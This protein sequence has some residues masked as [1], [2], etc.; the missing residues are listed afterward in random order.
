M[1]RWRSASLSV[2][3]RGSRHQFAMALALVSALPLLTLYYL[4]THRAH[5]SAGAQIGLVAM[6]AAVIAS[7]FLLLAKYPAAIQKLRVY[8]TK[9]V[10][11]EVPEKITLVQG[12]D[13]VAAIE[14]SMNLIVERMHERV[15]DM[16]DELHRIEWI[17]T[18]NV[19]AS[20][21]DQIRSERRS[22]VIRLADS[23]RAGSPFA[24]VNAE[25]L[26]DILGDSLDL[27]EHS[28][29]V[30]DAEG[31]C[32]LFVLASAWCRLLCGRD[33]VAKAPGAPSAAVCDRCHLREAGRKAVE[34]GAPADLLARC[35]IRAFAVPVVMGE[36]AVGAISFAYGNPPDKPAAVRAL[37]AARE[38]R[39]QDFER[40]AAQYEARPPFIVA[41]ARN[42]LLTSA[43]F[44]G[45]IMERKRAEQILSAKEEELR[46][47][48]D[49]LEELVRART[50][51]LE[52]ANKNLEHEIAE[53]LRAEK[54]KDDF[55]STVSHELRTPLSIA[56]EGVNLVLDRIP[57][58]ITPKQEHVLTLT[59]NN[60]SRLANIINDLLDISK[61]EAGCVVMNMGQVN[62]GTLIGETAASFE[63]KARQK[64]IEIR[65]RCGDGPL[66]AIGDA[67]RLMEV[68]INLVGNALKFTERGYVEISAERSGGEI[69]CRVRDT[70]VGIPEENQSQLFTKFRQFHRTEGAGE[71]GTGLG[72]AIAKSL[73]QLHHGR[74]WAES[75]VGQG[76]TFAFTLPVWNEEAALLERVRQA[77]TAAR[78]EQRTV[79]IVLI[80]ARS[81]I[82]AIAAEDMAGLRA[83]FLEHMKS[84]HVI[85][86]G[87]EGLPRRTDEIV[88]LTSVKGP[89]VPG[90]VARI[91]RNMT[92]LAPLVSPALPVTFAL[93]TCLYPD[94]GNGA[95]KVF[96]LLDERVENR[97]H[98]GG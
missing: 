80:R 36:Q 50:A 32:A 30:F 98:N 33:G 62:L 28:G 74:I 35:G 82:A 75:V 42:R 49:Q 65:T 56:K 64:G 44:L 17:L 60:I 3:A 5:L 48:R 88:V 59:K 37:A 95:E 18:R 81:A 27:I 39:D 90:L 34:T 2:S 73:V 25:E 38:V 51:E 47:H 72:L 85:R 68:F 21:V 7:G 94:E 31:R 86:A 29:A 83:A 92:K 19:G 77:L 46:R 54:L 23:Q 58:E 76:S 24:G 15:S 1:K 96:A 9:M 52:A 4:L 11:G 8:L 10:G 89:D 22:H 57:G 66:D 78:K 6:L 20:S 70:G 87:D 53:R 91:E 55:V 97:T 67:N 63:Q 16:R 26:E 41:M 69:V 40:A 84:S 45:E 12:E 79:L 61:I 93:A 71:R 43:K 14:S 13:D